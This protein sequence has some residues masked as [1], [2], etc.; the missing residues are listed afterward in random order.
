MKPISKHLILLLAFMPFFAYSQISKQFM[1]I[2]FDDRS[3]FI[4]ENCIK[5]IAEKHIKIQEKVWHNKKGVKR[6][7]VEEYNEWGGMTKKTV[8]DKNGK[9]I[10]QYTQVFDENNR[11]I[12]VN[13]ENKKGKTIE[14]REYDDF[15]NI[16]KQQFFKNG[17]LSTEIIKE[18]VAYRKLLK[19][20]I[21]SKGQL[22]HRTEMI[23]ENGQLLRSEH[24]N[25]KGKLT[26]AYDY[27]CKQAG[28]KIEPIKKTDQYCRY[29]SYDEAHIY[30]ISEKLD[31]KGRSTRFVTKLRA[32]D[33]VLV[34]HE[35]YNYEGALS[36]IV[37]YSGMISRPKEKIFYSKGVE[38]YRVVYDYNE[39]GQ[40]I[41]L[42]NQKADKTKV[43]QKW[44]Y[45]TNNT[46]LKMEVYD[47]KDQVHESFEYNILEF[48][49]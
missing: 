33:S 20:Q 28:E 46:L 36:Q 21:Y 42:S 7:L 43:L 9:Q 39:E 15:G 17:E 1:Y 27:S 49:N 25:K 47:D 6:K 3:G 13:R 18:F 48:F 32:S 12:Q 16:T 14:K 38:N 5:S 10:N 45:D 24:Y 11:S 23:Y 22:I 8:Y 34:Q 19:S 26:K 37:V 31:A 44:F 4:P 40:I 29:E 30:K 41:Q 35:Y 2:D